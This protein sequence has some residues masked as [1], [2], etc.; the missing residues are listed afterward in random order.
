MHSSYYSTMRASIL[1]TLGLG[2]GCT[3]GDGKT[4]TGA[5]SEGTSSSSSTSEG[6][7]E[8]SATA[9]TTEETSGSASA[10]GTTGSTGS[11]GMTGSTTDATSSGTTG[12]VVCEGSTPIDQADVDAGTPSGFELCPDGGI[13]RVEAVECKSPATPDS[14]TDNSG[15][16]CSSADDCT[17][18]PH[19][20]CQ[21]DMEF[22]GVLGATTCSCVYGC[23]TDDEC[24]AG[25]I[26]RCAGQGLGLYTE[27]IAGDC[28]DDGDCGDYLCGLSPDTCEP[29]GFQ[30]V[31]HGESD[32]CY[33]DSD[34]PDFQPCYYE[35][36][37]PA[38]WRCQDAVCGR[39][40]LVDEVARVAPVVD[41]GGLRADGWSSGLRPQTGGLS[42][43]QREQLVDHWSA[44]AAMEHASVAS[45]ARALLELMAVGAPADLLMAT[46]SALSDEI[47]HAQRAYAL[48]SAYADRELGP[49]ALPIEGALT[50]AGD[51]RRLAEAVA[52]EA[53]VAETLAAAEAR[54]ASE[55]ATCPV[56]RQAL[57]EI[58]DD[59][60]EHARL[61][62][63]TLAWLLEGLDQRDRDG[64]VAVL[65]GAV[66]SALEGVQN[67]P[68]E[69]GD[70]EGFGVLRGASRGA[71]V[72]CAVAEIVR[73]C[74]RAISGLEAA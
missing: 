27:C 49:G 11:T 74:A 18:F 23:A 1:L 44:I 68:Y 65:D 48:A 62:W 28:V 22:G 16:G 43:S 64:V 30:T 8:G 33:S 20:S 39:P 71:V 46:Q 29:G 41:L 55:R 40:F 32:L 2:V 4:S 19:G 63:R 12:A 67:T 70:L 72:R 25:E 59:E 69:D 47:R 3:G 17:E 51:R 36:S 24:G 58:A 53:C 42:S 10:T 66:A 13:H 5:S 57:A 26:C 38:Q 52:Q 9:S 37:D 21:Q 31:C 15:G 61:G 14:C 6:T 73:P 34:C 60:E 50:G 56:V 45:F 7:S 35:N 54:A